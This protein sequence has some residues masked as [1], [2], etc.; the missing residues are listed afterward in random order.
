MEE[1]IFQFLEEVV[2]KFMYLFTLILEIITKQN[3]IRYI[4]TIFIILVFPNPNQ[5]VENNSQGKNIFP[6]S[7][8][9]I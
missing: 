5:N 2:T 6:L 1:N 8:N 7:R 4:N 3:V 9:T